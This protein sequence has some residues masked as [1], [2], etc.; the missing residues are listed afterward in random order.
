[1]SSTVEC[2]QSQTGQGKLNKTKSEIAKVL[3]HKPNYIK[4]IAPTKMHKAYYT[5]HKVN[6]TQHIS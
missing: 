2:K 6:C 5:I 1:M 3:F 4:Q